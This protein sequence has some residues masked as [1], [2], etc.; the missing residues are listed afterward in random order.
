MNTLL[1]PPSYSLIDEIVSRIPRSG[2]DFSDYLIVFPGKR[3]SHFLRKALAQREKECLVP[4]LIFSIDQ[5]V[6][7]VYLKELGYS[8]RKLETIDSIAILYEIHKKAT[9]PL[10][11]KSFISP[12][13]FFSIGLKIYD[14]I[15]ELYI[16]G[17]E[18]NRMQEMKHIANEALP[19]QTSGRLQSLW[20]FYE[21]F[22]KTIEEQKY[23]TRSFRYRIVSERINRSNLGRFQK[24]FIAG[25]FSL[26][27]S[28]KAI[29][30]KISIWNNSL[31]IF[32]EGTGIEEKLEQAG[33]KPEKI[34]N[35][36][37]KEE[38]HPGP[39]YYFYQSPDTHGQVFGLSKII[40]NELSKDILSSENN[41]ILVPSPKTLFPLLHQTLAIF[42][43]EDFN[44]SM[45]Y[46]LQRT[47]IFG[48]FNNLMNLITSLEEE[49][50]YVPDYLKFILHPYTKNIYF[51]RR[52]DLT[53]IIFHAIE[54][55]LTNRRSSSFVTLEEIEED[56]VF[57]E[58]ISKELTKTEAFR[59][60][61]FS[62]GI[63]KE[64]IK[65]IHGNIINKF[66][67]F[68]NIND[69]ALKCIDVLVYITNHST[70][71]QHPL[72]YPFAE[73]FIKSLNLIANSLFKEISFNKRASYFNFLKK[74]ILIC[75][76]PF[77]GT[78]LK[79]LQVLGFLEIR[80][81]KFDKVFILDANEGILPNV[82]T[83]DSLLPYKVR[84]ALGVSTY[85]DREKIS[86]Y[87][88]DTLIKSAREAHV[89]FVE[90]NKKEK[91]RFV[92]KILWE[93]QKKEKKADSKTYIQSIRYKVK[94]N[95]EDP[96][97][98]KKTKEMVA[99]LKTFFYSA[100]SVDTYLRC[101]L[102]FYYRF[103]LGFDEKKSIKGNIE[104]VEIGNFVHTLLSVY[105]QKRTGMKLDIKN[106]NFEEMDQLVN[107]LFE[108]NFGEEL[109]GPAFI[110]NIQIK[111]RMRD[112]LE[113]YQSS[114]IKNNHIIILEIEHKLKAFV[115]SFNLKGKFDRI[116]K[117]NEE[118]L[119]IDYKTSSSSNALKINFSKL[120]PDDRATWKASIGSL[121]LPFYL[122]LFCAK[123]GASI[124]K[125]NGVFVPLGLA[126]MD[127]KIELP[128]FQAKEE[129]LN[130]FPV[131]QGIIFK[132][133]NEIIN[134]D[135]P[136][137]AGLE[138]K[139]TCSYCSFQSICGT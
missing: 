13:N 28:E 77:A 74:Y 106:I 130:Y 95:S 52:A 76:A 84:K 139:K 24:I 114:L 37:K 118:I 43:R 97:P 7:Y 17:V 89:F 88:F 125:M 93:K 96:L 78:P 57:F 79:G 5:F 2:K 54:K 111:R 11:G 82:P 131:L 65:D 34:K 86:A 112:F 50:F 129:A 48:F 94:L 29:F 113:K 123:T 55:K 46:P 9:K 8:G 124:E 119:I 92:Q 85:V 126:A 127:E 137:Q 59:N 69:F 102:M 53:R 56:N 71:S 30:K 10:G 32:Q 73:E 4:P 58:E 3:P 40:K 107:K 72:F 67:S 42:N 1:I 47:P 116:E 109:T 120:I 20:H 63:L 100:S 75:R 99:F 103:V 26:T 83:E 138:R 132:I 51:N 35:I 62:A 105:F 64:H 66:R 39:D 44:I 70:A 18:S 133:L 87:Y 80:N 101:P 117:R 81:L 128:L 31:F 21:R 36:N 90:M 115:N 134:P 136:F 135:I 98:I 27:K 22:Y 12:D 16:E 68:K 33:F 49:K 108:K 104:K 45:G 19:E 6:D 110:L 23:T 41:V 14:A 60:I 38:D 121:Q 25:F 15:E 61:V 122:T 91:S